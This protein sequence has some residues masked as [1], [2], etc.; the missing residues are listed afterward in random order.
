MAATK[1]SD[2]WHVMVVP[3][4]GLEPKTV[5][6]AVTR[7]VASLEKSLADLE[8]GSKHT[9]TALLRALLGVFR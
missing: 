1:G 7:F 8:Q 5:S 4:P 9:A 2:V 3:T 6:G